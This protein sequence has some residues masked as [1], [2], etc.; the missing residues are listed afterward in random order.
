MTTPYDTSDDIEEPLDPTAEARL[1][2]YFHAQPEQPPAIEPLWRRLAP[3]LEERSATDS[4]PASPQ[5][6]VENVAQLPMT[7]VPGTS[8]QDH[9][10]TRAVRTRAVRRTLGNLAQLAAVLVICLGVFALLRNQVQTTPG[11]SNTNGNHRYEL[12]WQK[13]KLPAGVMLHDGALSNSDNDAANATLTVAPSNGAV[14]YICQVTSSGKALIWRTTDAGQHWSLLPPLPILVPRHGYGIIVDANDPLTIELSIVDSD[15][16]GYLLM[17]GAAQWRQLPHYTLFFSSWN[18]TYYKIDVSANGRDTATP[19]KIARIYRSA[20]QMQ[21]WREINDAALIS[22]SA[23]DTPPSLAKKGFGVRQLWVQPNTGEMLAQTSDGALWRSLDRGNSWTRIKF[24][25]LPPASQLTPTPG[26]TVNEGSIADAVVYVAQPTGA[27]PFSLCAIVLDRQPIAYNV[28]PFY[29]SSD[30]GQ[31]W[32]RR[33]RPAVE[34][35]NGRPATYVVPWLMLK[36]GTLI[37]WDVQ[38]ISAFPGNNPAAP[39]AHVIGVIPAPHSPDT[40]PSGLIGSTEGGAVL[41]QPIDMQTL[42][43]AIYHAP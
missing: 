35:G 8:S 18:G 37:G 23:I 17:L 9:I 34:W 42:W 16:T 1:R 7:P 12:S 24:P 31:T 25:A 10:R 26:E 21:T 30:G 43:V 4:P 36:D 5:S 38:T 39:A 14:A 13:V 19:S 20:D 27:Q 2:D 6:M 29:C 40:V 33:P 11:T 15:G 32:V 3:Q 22:Q 28:A 41:W